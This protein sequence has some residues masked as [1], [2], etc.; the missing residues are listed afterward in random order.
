MTANQVGTNFRSN[1]STQQVNVARQTSSK[2]SKETSAWG[3]TD[4]N[5]DGKIDEKDVWAEYEQGLIDAGD[6]YEI[7]QNYESLEQGSLDTL[8]A[9][10]DKALQEQTTAKKDY[11]TAQTNN[12]NDVKQSLQSD[13][14][15]LDENIKNYDAKI[16]N[17]DDAIKEQKKLQKSASYKTIPSYK[18]QVDADLKYA[19]EQ[20]TRLVSQRD[21]AIERR[22]NKQEI[23]KNEDKLKEEANSRLHDEIKTETET[24]L[25]GAYY[26]YALADQ[27][28]NKTNSTKEEQQSKVKNITINTLEMG[29]K[30]IDEA[31]NKNKQVHAD[32]KKLEKQKAELQKQLDELKKQ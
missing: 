14:N 21:N 17:Y 22:K 10:Y 31:I 19:E 24:A 16:S 25:S 13:I 12:L 29:I 4:Y 6:A 15:S 18:E 26:K 7:L 8:I 30:A 32:T 28:L 2:G 1:K 3:M 23:L 5:Q 20:K 9:N 27:N 11:E